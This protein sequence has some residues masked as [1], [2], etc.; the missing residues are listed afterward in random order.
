M[1]EKPDT[2]HHHGLMLGMHPLLAALESATE[3]G[4]DGAWFCAFIR[5]CLCRIPLDHR[6]E[7]VRFGGSR[8]GFKRSSK[9][10]IMTTGFEIGRFGGIGDGFSRSNKGHLFF[11]AGA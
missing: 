7:I 5:P 4:I 10:H 1:D 2:K 6:S 11:G 8:D 3:R 9:G